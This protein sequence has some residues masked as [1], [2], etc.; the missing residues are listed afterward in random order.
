MVFGLW[1]YMQIKMIG[2]DIKTTFARN[3]NKIVCIRMFY[4][5]RIVALYLKMFRPFC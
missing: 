1:Q 3:S 2:G 5:I 4:C